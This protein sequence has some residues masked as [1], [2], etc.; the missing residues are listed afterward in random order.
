MEPKGSKAALERREPKAHRGHKGPLVH[1]GFKVP[2]DLKA[3]LE[4]KGLK[5]PQ[6]LKGRPGYR[7]ARDPRA[8]KDLSALKD[9][10]VPK[11]RLALKEARALLAPKELPALKGHK[12]LK[13]LQGPA[14]VLQPFRRSSMTSTPRMS[15]GFISAK[16]GGRCKTRMAPPAP[17]ARVERRWPLPV[18]MPQASLAFIPTALLAGCP[19][20]MTA[21]NSGWAEALRRGRRAS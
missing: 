8:P 17:P 21:V 16:P 18:P 20:I 4:L 12:D 1:R 19:C 3:R 6:A 7:V 14:R 11:E 9:P 15:S 13:A 2:R 5:A 10:Q